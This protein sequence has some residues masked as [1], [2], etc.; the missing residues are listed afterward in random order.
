MYATCAVPRLVKGIH[1]IDTKIGKHDQYSHHNNE[2][3]KVSV[4]PSHKHHRTAVYLIADFGNYPPSFTRVIVIMPTRGA[5][6]QPAY[7][8]GSVQGTISELI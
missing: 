3:T 5:A 2:N 8:P 4:L 6:I 7:S 1:R